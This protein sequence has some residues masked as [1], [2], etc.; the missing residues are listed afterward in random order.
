[1]NSLAGR[2][3]A[4]MTRAGKTQSDVANAVGISQAAVQ[5]ITSGKS[6][7][8]SKIK[9]I[10]DFLG[11]NR[12][13]LEF[14]EQADQVMG[15]FDVWSGDE[16]SSDD[17]DVPFLKE[18]E[19]AAGNGLVP[20]QDYNGFKL[21]F[22]RSTLRRLG[23][24]P[25]NAVCVSVKGDSMEPV[26][27]DGSTV[28]VDTGRKNIVDGKMYAVSIR[29]LLK[30]KVLVQLS[31]NTVRVKSYNSSEYPD[32]DVDIEDIE[33]EGWVFWSASTY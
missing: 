5:K 33:V 17:V 32:E 16:S 8:S 15:G 24:D 22:A 2:L 23:V 7:T 18:T 26:L 12:M 14:G 31:S 3:K 13:W 11:V 25:S 10:A 27:K 28:G 4:S 6:K 21:K 9:E 20:N 1:M 19:L 29:G 30:I